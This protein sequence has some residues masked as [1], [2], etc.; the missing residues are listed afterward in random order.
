MRNAPPDTRCAHED[1]R[2]G[3]ESMR[4]GSGQGGL[5]TELF[6]GKQDNT[7]ADVGNGASYA[8][9]CSCIAI[10]CIQTQDH[11]QKT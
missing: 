7:H 10:A 8:N 11:D 2:K 1:G 4:S 9:L 6:K 5:S 3:C